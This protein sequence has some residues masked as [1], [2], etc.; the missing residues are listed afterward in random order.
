MSLE[1][2]NLGYILSAT[3]FI[4]GLK[5]LSSPATAVRG[6]YLSAWAM[7]IAVVVTLLDERVISY[8]W[9]IAGAV[10]G[11]VIGWWAAVKVEMTKMPEMVAAF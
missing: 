9:M 1:L 10:V 4:L 2:V 7:L 8:E 11:T 6:N 5:M 3:L